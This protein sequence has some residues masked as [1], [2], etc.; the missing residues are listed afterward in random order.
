MGMD[1]DARAILCGN[2]IGPVTW[3]E[4]REIGVLERLCANASVGTACT[5][6]Q[7]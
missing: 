3:L 2:V 1:N 7:L 4:E 6:V 5:T